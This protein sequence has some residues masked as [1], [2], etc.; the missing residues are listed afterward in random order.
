MFSMPSTVFGS[1]ATTT[2]YGEIWSLLLWSQEFTNPNEENGP[3]AEKTNK[4][5]QDLEP[6]GPS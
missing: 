4:N 3:Q 5:G 2:R 6:K 1:R